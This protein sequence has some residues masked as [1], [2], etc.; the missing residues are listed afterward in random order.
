MPDDPDE[1]F[2]IHTVLQHRP[3]RAVRA[4]KAGHHELE[5]YAPGD[6]A[7]VVP[8]NTV[9]TVDAMVEGI[10]WDD[11]LE[12]SDVGWKLV[13]A[14]ASDINAMGATPHWAVLTLCLPRP[15]DREWVTS[16]AQGL[17]KAL[18]AWNIAL[19]G[20]DTTRS[21]TGR[22]ASLTL[23]GTTHHPIGRHS[24]QAGDDI[25][26]SGH[27]G[28]AAAGFFIDGCS[29]E[30]LRR[31]MPPIGLGPALGHLPTAM[32]DISD[33]ITTDLAK[34][35]TASGTGASI[36]PDDL[37]IHPLLA[38]HVD[39]IPMMVGFGE[40]YELLF[41]ATPEHRHSIEAIGAEFGHPLT[42]IGQLNEQ[43][44]LGPILNGRA[45]PDVLFSHF[46]EANA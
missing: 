14:N 46:A 38:Q 13:A 1:S 3:A 40:E 30:A 25:W 39:P 6:D 24:A 32:M 36:N 33:G 23:T 7:A 28:G 12:A 8:G 29:L 17:G 19:V 22:M 45:W 9:V 44:D 41:T 20:G 5:S 10:H 43:A 2:V 21:P 35:C 42:R 27:L 15:L 16:F 11:R 4:A 31:P 26:V 37:P 18:E 34:L